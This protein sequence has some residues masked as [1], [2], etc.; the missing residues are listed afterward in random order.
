MNRAKGKWAQTKGKA[1]EEE[2]AQVQ[3]EKAAGK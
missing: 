3:T 1:I 2:K